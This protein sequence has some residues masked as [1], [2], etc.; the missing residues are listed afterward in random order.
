M[1]PGAAKC[2]HG[3]QWG[4]YVQATIRPRAEHRETPDRTASARQAV[5]AGRAGGLG[6]CNRRLSRGTCIFIPALA[7]NQSLLDRSVVEGDGVR[8]PKSMVWV[9][10]A[11]SSWAATTSWRG[12][13]SDPR[14][15][16][17]CA[18]FW[19]DRTHVTNAQF[20]EFVKATGYVT[21]A[22]RKPD[23]ETLRV[24]VP[25]GTPRPPDSATGRRAPWCSSAPISR[26]RSMTGR[27]GGP[28]YPAP[29]GGIRYG[30]GSDIAGKDDHPVVQVSY[31]DAQ[32]YARWAGKRLPTEAEWEFA[33]RGGLEQ[34]TYSW[35]DEYTVDGKAMANTWDTSRQAVPG[36]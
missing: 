26:C 35:G 11:N 25:E 2:E 34:A 28:T 17:A 36:S 23:W 24:Q 10:A 14:I 19:M 31:E 3:P 21:T 29:T 22:E 32:A 9:P 12:P 27:A 1:I 4:R 30:P 5:R 8:G 7:G 15:A 13:T 6:G 20:A 16:C 33:A 18:G